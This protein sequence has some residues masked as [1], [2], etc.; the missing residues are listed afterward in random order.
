M[1]FLLSIRILCIRPSQSDTADRARCTQTPLF[2]S[3][4]CAQRK[5]KNSKK[6]YALA[7]FRTASRKVELYRAPVSTCNNSNCRLNFANFRFVFSWKTTKERERNY[8]SCISAMWISNRISNQIYVLPFLSNRS[9]LVR[10]L[11]RFASVLITCLRL[12]NL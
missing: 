9:K 1:L 2:G 6:V 7:A 3:I 8:G 12:L 11:G 5:V 10:S 4:N